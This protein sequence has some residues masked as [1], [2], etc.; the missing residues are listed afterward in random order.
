MK[1]QDTFACSHGRTKILPCA[2]SLR[3]LALRQDDNF[4]GGRLVLASFARAG[5]LRLWSAA[6]RLEMEQLSLHRDW[7]GQRGGD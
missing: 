2:R 5:Q 1:A 6:G 7:R 4:V 3:S